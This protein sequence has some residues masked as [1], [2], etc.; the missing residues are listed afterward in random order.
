MTGPPHRHLEQTWSRD[1][2]EL[3]PPRIELDEPGHS[4]P[5]LRCA[6]ELDGS[7]AAE[8]AALLE[9][10]CECDVDGLLLDFADVELLDAR[11]LAVIE[12]ARSRLGQRGAP[13]RIVAG[14]QPL[15]LLRLTGLAERMA[16]LPCRPHSQR[17][18]PPPAERAG[19]GAAAG[20]SFESWPSR[21]SSSRS[22]TPMS[23]PTGVAT[24]R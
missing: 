1:L 23:A 5:V 15:R 18:R 24:T 12:S 2:G 11:V 10:I 7:I 20:H 16:T 17:H 22:P 9:A 21:S 14:G 8:L 19:I 4:H 6:G 3:R 13:L